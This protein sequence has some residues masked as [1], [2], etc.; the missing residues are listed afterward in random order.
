[1]CIPNIYCR[2]HYK[3]GKMATNSISKF[4]EHYLAVN[5]EEENLSESLNEIL[6]EENLEDQGNSVTKFAELGSEKQQT[7]LVVD[8]DPP[9]NDVDKIAEMERMVCVFCYFC[10]ILLFFGSFLFYLF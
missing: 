6:L 7:D 4:C 1:M 3:M 2:V 9:I 8:G 10:H 5:G